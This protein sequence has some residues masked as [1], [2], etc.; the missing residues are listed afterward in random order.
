MS[1]VGEGT[2]FVQLSLSRT[3]YPSAV[4]KYEDTITQTNSARLEINN[5]G[6]QYFVGINTTGQF[7]ASQDYVTNAITGAIN[8]SY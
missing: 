8:S 3:N 2:T 4:L 6:V 7:L 5:K 1:K